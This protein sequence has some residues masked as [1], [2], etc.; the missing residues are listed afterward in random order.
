[1][2]TLAYRDISR[3]QLKNSQFYFHR[4]QSSKFSGFPKKV[5]QTTLGFILTTECLSSSN[6]KDLKDPYIPRKS[7]RIFN[8]QQSLRISH[9]QQSRIYF[10]RQQSK[11]LLSPAVKDLFPSTKQLIILHAHTLH[12]Y[13]INIDKT[14]FIASYIS[15]NITLCFS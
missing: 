6:S 1:M 15:C 12:S 14:H 4:S 11:I 5:S 2:A 13:I 3:N 9:P 8:P 10:P 7:L